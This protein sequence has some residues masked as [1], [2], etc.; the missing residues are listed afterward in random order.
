[1]TT[2]VPPVA[3]VLRTA[4]E[5]V[6]HLAAVADG[7]EPN[8]VLADGPDRE[9]SPITV[10]YDDSTGDLTDALT[11]PTAFGDV[12]PYSLLEGAASELDLTLTECGDTYREWTGD[13]D[14]IPV[15]L[16]LY[17]PDDGPPLLRRLRYKL[18]GVALLAGAAAAGAAVALAVRRRSAP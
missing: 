17:L 6:A 10:V 15:T 1:M 13:A 5:Y 3:T 2:T 8:H 9:G 12:D 14:G 11:A 16:V 4:A 18:S 7:V